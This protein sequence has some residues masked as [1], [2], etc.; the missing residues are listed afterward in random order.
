MLPVVSYLGID[1]SSTML[2][3]VEIHRRMAS[4]VPITPSCS[5]AEIFQESLYQL[6][7]SSDVVYSIV[8]I[9]VPIQMLALHKQIL[10]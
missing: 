9:S 2:N 1:V 10:K 4:L 8:K 6:Y 7:S 3:C 5:E